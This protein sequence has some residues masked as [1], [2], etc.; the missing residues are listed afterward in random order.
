MNFEMTKI[1]VVDDDPAVLRMLARVLEGP[2]Q[3]IDTATDGGSAIAKLTATSYDVIISDIAMPGM[4]GIE[5]LGAVRTHDLDVPIVLVTGQPSLETAIQALEFGAFR[6][7]TKPVDLAQLRAVVTQAARLHALAVLKR[8]ALT[9]VGEEGKQ[10][11]DRASLEGRFENALN[12][13][14]IACQPIISWRDRTIFGYE[15]LMRSSEPTLA[16][17]LA[18][19][20][21]AER[22]GRVH[23]MG[24]NTRAA[25]AEAAT[26]LP[27]GALLFVNLHPSDLSDDDLLS[28]SSPLAPLAKRIVLEI[29]ERSTLDEIKDLEARLKTLRSMGF[30]L[31][32]DDLGAGYA[33]LT[34]MTRLEPEVVKFDMGLIRGVDQSPK[35]QR[36]IRSMKKLCDELGTIVVTE[37]VETAPERDTLV[38]L[39]CDLFQGYL[40]A[41]PARGFP[42]PAW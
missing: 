26:A 24:R 25:T 38:E 11:G 14:W 20:D 3:T 9:L 15:A 5:L 22:L 18:M 19:I 31:A 8:E 12:L 36:V 35:K 42:A 10:L 32:I 37:G 39:G 2:E 41:R 16:N 29:T 34:T 27:D 21:A 30:R 28:A 4:D 23:A 7:L 17:P 40:F 13:V 33:G 1:L 6:Y